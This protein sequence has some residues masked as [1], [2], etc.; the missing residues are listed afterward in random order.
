MLKSFKYIFSPSSIHTQ[1]PVMTKLKYHTDMS[2]QTLYSVLS[3][4]TFSSHYSLDSSW[5][6]CDRLCKPGFGEISAILLC[7]SSQ[8]VRLNGSG[9]WT[10]IVRSLQ[11]CEI[12]FKSEALAGPLKDIYRVFPKPLLRCLGCVLRVIVLLESKVLSA[13]GQVFTVGFLL[14]SLTK[15]LLVRLLSLAGWPTLGSPGP[16]FSISQLLRWLCSWERSKF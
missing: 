13:L 14:T 16:T 15:A 7:R 9:Q 3:W 12:A 10:A 11:R 5:V 6:W 8:A 1:Y 2:I 4:S